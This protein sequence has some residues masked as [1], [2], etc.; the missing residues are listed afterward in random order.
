MLTGNGLVSWQ[1]NEPTQY[2]GRQ[3]Q[4]FSPESR[5]FTQAYAKYSSDYIEAQMQGID[6][7]NPYAW[8]TRLI[9]MADIVRPTAAIQRNFDDYKMILVADRDIEYIMPGSKIVAMGSTWLVVNPM[10][11]SGSDG[12]AVIRRCNAVWNYLDFY[13][14]VQSEPILVENQRAN[15]N[16]SDNQQSLLITKGY[17]NVICQY[18]DATRQIDTNTRMILGTGAYRVTGYSDFETEFTGD[19][20]SVRTL[21]FVVRYEEPNAVIDD[22]ENHV[23]GGKSFTWNVQIAEA[24]S[25]RVGST[26][27]F[28]ASS[29]RNGETVTP[30]EAQPVSYLWA[31]ADENVVTVDEN[32]LVTAIAEGETTITATL[33][34]NPVYSVTVPV[35]VT[36]TTDG[37]EFTTSVPASLGAF[38]RVTIGAT[39]FEDGAETEEPLTWEFSGADKTAF[40]TDVSAFGT[41][42]TILCYGFS[43]TPL[44]VTVR[45]GTDAVTA[46]I[47][48]EGI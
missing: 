11:V 35:K 31:S 42:A 10:N 38:E 27:Q 32:G 16:D 2:D 28:T 7:E 25:L 30:T 26:A 14:N 19:Y 4:Y 24:G 3:R 17:F 40:S 21:S 8:Q 29:V 39:Y 36:Q 22:M 1:N 15:A 34:Q 6:R 33:E 13:G 18:N 46:S 45:H 23:A 43:E 20:G 44:N 47:R 48:L 37:V 9:R 5:T 12:S 41:S